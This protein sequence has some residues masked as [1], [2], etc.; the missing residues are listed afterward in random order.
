MK[1]LQ[2]I[3]KLSTLLIFLL[4]GIISS[5]ATIAFPD[6]SSDWL[7]VSL[8]IIFFI[9]IFL[10][11]FYINNIR[12]NV[13]KNETKSPIAVDILGLSFGFLAAFFSLPVAFDILLWDVF[14]EIG[15]TIFVLVI[16]CILLTFSGIKLMHYLY[17]YI[18]KP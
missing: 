8:G 5:V 11:L 16:Y 6:R 7:T 14:G 18:K 12:N 4:S 3:K 17:S 9:T 15:G 10:N 13:S 1:Y 2:Q